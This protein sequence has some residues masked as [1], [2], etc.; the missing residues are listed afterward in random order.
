MTFRQME[1]FLAVCECGSITK[2]SREHH[3]SPQGI[4]RMI[5]DLEKELSCE[6]L[7]RSL[8]GVSVTA[9]GSFLY[10]ECRRILKWKDGLPLAISQCAE[11]QRETVELGMA[12]GVIGAVHG[13]LFSDFEALYPGVQIRYSDNTDLA[14][15]AQLDRG[16]YDFCL[17]TGVLDADKFEKRTLARQQI[18]LCIPAGHE[19]ENRRTVGMQD[20]D[21]QHFVMFS[22]QFFIRHDFD[23]ICREAGAAPVVDYVSNDFNSLMALAQQNRLLFTV[24]AFCVR[25]LGSQCRYVPFPEDRF[26][27][28]VCLVKGKRRELSGAAAEFWDYLE[29]A[30]SGRTIRTAEG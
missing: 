14:L 13:T 24:P 26:Q 27:W 22:T 7:H 4:S 28:S 5:L 6:L 11:A 18:M 23:R 9:Q 17:T 19:F 30:I 25:F 1:L 21:G 15:E 16:E 2:A 3:I 20:L 12:F 29:G 10:E 8:S